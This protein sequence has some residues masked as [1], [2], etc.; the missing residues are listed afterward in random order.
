M[1]GP[2]AAPPAAQCRAQ[3]PA[4]GEGAAYAST[5]ESN[6]GSPNDGLRGRLVPPTV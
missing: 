6:N 2:D 1:S 5:M 3:N 4:G